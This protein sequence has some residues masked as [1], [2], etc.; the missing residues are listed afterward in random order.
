[1]PSAVNPLELDHNRVGDP[2]DAQ[3]VYPPVGVLKRP[4]SSATIKSSSPSRE[5]SCLIA[6]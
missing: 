5:T 1:M 2:V 6:T 3:E 4:N